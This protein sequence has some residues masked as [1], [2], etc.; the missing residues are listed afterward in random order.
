MLVERIIRREIL[1]SPPLEK[2]LIVYA[3]R[4]PVED[5]IVIARSI[6]ENNQQL[7]LA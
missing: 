2:Q 4:D 5:I 7:F 6:L 3:Q 1:D